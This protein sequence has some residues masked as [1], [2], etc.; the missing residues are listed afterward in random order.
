MSAGVNMSHGALRRTSLKVA[1]GCSLEGP[2]GTGHPGR[3][4]AVFGD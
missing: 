4:G 3:M 1:G 2:P